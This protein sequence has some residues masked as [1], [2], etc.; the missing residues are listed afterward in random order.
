MTRLIIL[1]RGVAKGG[2]GEFPIVSPLVYVFTIDGVGVA[3][4]RYIQNNASF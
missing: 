2:G 4:N 1:H 3:L